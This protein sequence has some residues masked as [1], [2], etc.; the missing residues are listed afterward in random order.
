MG[1]LVINDMRTTG[2]ILLINLFSLCSIFK[3]S[4]ADHT[5]NVESDVVSETANEEDG[6]ATHQP[7][8]ILI[9]FDGGINIL[10]D[11]VNETIIIDEYYYSLSQEPININIVNAISDT[12]IVSNHVC[13]KHSPLRKGDVAFILLEYSHKIITHQLFNYQWD[14]LS[15][16]C[17]Y[18]YGQLDWVEEN[19]DILKET[20]LK[21]Y[22]N[23]DKPHN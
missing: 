17:L 16:T 1:F 21:E 8:T 5:S 13:S 7:D 9:E 12:S 23:K 15:D 11:N 22:F 3:C 19:R 18:F 4:E 2:I 10:W 6:M 20:I 14:V